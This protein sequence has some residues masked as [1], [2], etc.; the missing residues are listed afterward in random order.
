MDLKFSII[1][2]VYN[3]PTELDELLESI[4]KQDF[5]NSFEV[6]VVEDGSE[7]PSKEIVK[8]YQDQIQIHYFFKENSGPG[9][10]RNF[11]MQKSSGNY[12]IILDSDCILPVQYLK[13]VSNGLNRNYTDAFGGADAAHESFSTSQ[14]A[15]SYAMTS[16]L[17]TGGIRGKKNTK[18]NF[19]PRSFNMGLSKKAIIETNGFGDLNYGEDI[20]LTFRLWEKGIKT[21][22]IEKAYVF[23]KRRI[24]WQSFFNQTYNFGAAR[25]ILNKL[26][27]GTSK[28]T[29]WFP[30]LFI[31]IIDIAIISLIFSIEILIIFLLSYLMLIFLN[32]LYKNKKL[33]IA[34]KSVMAS[35]VMF[36]GYGLGFLRSTVRLHILN[37][38]VKDTFPEMF[39]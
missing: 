16:V 1:I 32:S 9:L 34:L 8:K 24:N 33:I 13:E 17:T 6:I 14:Q 35:L 21:Q 39:N 38:S 30:T 7:I 10:S 37:K 12:F 15:I 27:S 25:P 2:P 31:L 28:L 29:Y 26:H 18:N 19:Q 22:F 4:S 20:D 36:Y 11:G 23:H 5:Q 3:R